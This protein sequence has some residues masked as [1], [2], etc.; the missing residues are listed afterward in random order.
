MILINIINI[1]KCFKISLHSCFCCCYKKK[2][3][4]AEK[5]QI[6]KDAIKLINS[7][8]NEINLLKK[9]RNTKDEELKELFSSIQDKSKERKNL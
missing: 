6:K 5:M 1:K 4:D 3:E 7:M 8:S 9:L 2:N